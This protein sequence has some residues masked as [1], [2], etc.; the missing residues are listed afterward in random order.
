VVNSLLVAR[1]GHVGLAA[2]TSTVAL[3]NFILLMLFMRGKLG[4]LEGRQLGGSLL[5]ICGATIPMAAVAWFTSELASELPIGGLT[6]RFVRVGASIALATIVFYW[7]CRFLK[8]AELD[9]AINAI[10]GR[11]LRLARR[12]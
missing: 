3:V 6:L 12:K 10:A 1:F 2:S 7:G 4:S 8:I 5:R 11:F 9:E